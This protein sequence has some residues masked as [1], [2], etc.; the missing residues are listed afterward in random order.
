MNDFKQL[1]HIASTKGLHLSCIKY[2]TNINIKKHHF[3][4]FDIFIPK[5]FDSMA[6][7]RKRDY[8]FSRKCA[9]T[10]LMLMGCR[11]HRIKLHNK[12]DGQIM[13]PFGFIGSISHTQGCAMACIGLKNTTHYL[14]VDIERPMEQSVT[15]QIFALISH[16]SQADALQAYC[17]QLRLP[18]NIVTTIIFSAKE[19]FFKAIYPIDNRLFNFSDIKV[20]KITNK[21]VFLK[22]SIQGHSMHK[23]IIPVH[24]AISEDFIYTVTFGMNH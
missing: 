4:L 7:K 23:H 20:V 1:N 8:F 6:Q 15:T 19:S 21:T 12:A 24:Y 22:L 14:G 13:W 2:P 9:K 18:A 10:L 5:K 11:E 16:C 17:S 3:W